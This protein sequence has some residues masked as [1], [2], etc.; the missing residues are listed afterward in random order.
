MRTFFRIASFDRVAPVSLALVLVLAAAP[1]GAHVVDTSNDSPDAA[2]GDGACADTSGACSLRAATEESAAQGT[3]QTILV[4]GGFYTLFLG[5]LVLGP[6]VEIQAIQPIAARPVIV[7]TV[8]GDRVFD[9]GPGASA[10][11]V[12]LVVQGGSGSEGGCAHVDGGLLVLVNVDFGMCSSTGDGGALLV[13]GGADVTMLLGA[14]RFNF[15]GSRGGA[16]A[17]LADSSFQSDGTVVEDNVAMFEGGASY[18][19]D[20][21]VVYRR[22]NVQHND[23]LVGGAFSNVNASAAYHVCSLVRNRVDSGG[24]AG[25]QSQGTLEFV[26]VTVSEN[27]GGFETGGL[28]VDRADTRLEHTTVFNNTGEFAAGLL[29]LVNAPPPGPTTVPPVVL[30]HSIVSG[31]GPGDDIDAFS[32][33]I[34]TSAGH[35]VL[36]V[37][38][39]FANVVPSTSDQVGVTAPDLAPLAPNGGGL[40]SNRPR[41]GSPA[42]DAGSTAPSAV[43]VANFDV[44]DVMRPQDGNG[45]LVAERDA[46]AYEITP[47]EDGLDNDG[48]ALVDTADSGCTG[49]TDTSEDP[50]CSDALDNDEDGFTDWPND[51]Q[52]DT[53][54]DN[55]EGNGCARQA[56]LLPLLA[57]WLRRRRFSARR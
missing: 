44:R 9:V 52:C 56:A 49:V 25:I 22:C 11:L 53:P 21:A 5:P 39:S 31:N 6:D 20:S 8:S 4:P 30:D 13:T 36:G 2:P 17:V 41:P 27:D 45:D 54:E 40:P 7:Q 10:R 48:N 18:A 51:T 55:T 37:F 26:A 50:Q 23:A 43:P 46:G 15:A 38:S 1:V 42:V 12:G 28:I 32:P 35:N 14:F 24:G 29:T 47:C 34:V 57:I 19:E 3:P 33:A 16:V